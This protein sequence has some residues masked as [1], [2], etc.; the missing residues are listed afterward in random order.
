MRSLI[1]I[2]QAHSKA[3]H[4]LYSPPSFTSPLI[5]KSNGPQR[6]K[7]KSCRSNIK[8]SISHHR[9]DPS[10][11]H[12]NQTTT[13][14]APFV[15]RKGRERSERGM[16]AAARGP[17][18]PNQQHTHQRNTP[19]NHHRPFRATTGARAQRAGYA[20]GGEGPL[21]TKPPNHPINASHPS[22]TTAPF[23]RRKGRE[24]SDRGMPGAAR[25]PYQPNHQTIPSTQPTQQPTP[26][27]SPS[28]KSQKS[29]FRQHANQHIR[30]T[31][32]SEPVRDS[33]AL[34]SADPPEPSGQRRMCQDRD[35]DDRQ[36]TR[37]RASQRGARLRFP[38]PEW[39]LATH[40]TR[41]RVG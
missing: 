33:A 6:T 36:E 17:Y 31:I 37:R 9:S 41:S 30:A 19:I 25:G 5:I 22:T 26:I 14:H 38:A 23:V 35:S 21:P 20:R 10:G 4:H 16:P 8:A 29:R 13:T 28:F 1:P 12:T 7:P 2:L 15:R 40:R 18:Q 11:H 24:C 32:K 27:H 34:T 39:S 3:H